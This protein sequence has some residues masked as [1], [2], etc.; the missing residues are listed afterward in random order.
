MKQEIALVTGVSSGIGRAIAATLA[1]SGY[2]VF[3]TV[4]AVDGDVPPGVDKTVLDVRDEA[5]IGAAVAGILS[6]VGRIDVL[7]NNAG[8]GLVGAIEETDIEQAQALFDVNFFGAVRVT[9][10]VLPAM[11]AQR[12]GRILFVGSIAGLAPTPFMSFYAAS[13]H[14]LEGYSESLDHEMRSMG[15]RSI[16]IEPG[17]MKTRI[18]QSSVRAAHVI[19]DYVSVARKAAESLTANVEKGEDPS[20]VA[21]MVVRALQAARPRLRYPVGKGAVTLARF[22]R[23]M[24]AAMFDRGLRKALQLDN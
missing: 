22:R 13:K 5:S 12:K 8:G 9:K 23:L 18:D 16:L 4:R 20:I 1:E 6:S 10:A 21:R 15:V 3:G 17:F 14:A 24:P 2:R 11:R 7:V 19:Q